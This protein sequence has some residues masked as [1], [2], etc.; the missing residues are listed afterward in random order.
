MEGWNVCTPRLESKNLP[1]L[2]YWFR[3]RHTLTILASMT[4]KILRL[5]VRCAVLVLCGCNVV[6]LYADNAQNQR[7][8]IL[9]LLA[10]DWAWPHASCLGTPGIQTPT[11]DRL[12]REGVLFRNAHVAAPSCAPS[13]AAM[14]TG[15][16]HWRLEKGV[17]LFGTLSAKF[18][19]YAT[20]LEQAGYFVAVTG[21]GYGPGFIEEIT[22]DPPKRFSP[23]GRPFKDFD[24]FQKVRPRDK[25]FCLLFG[26]HQPHRPYTVGS[27]VKG[28]IDPSKIQVPPYLP[29]N[30]VV[31]SDIADHYIAAQAF[32]REAG[33]VLAA[34][35]KSGELD[36]TLVVMSG[37]NWWP[38]P[39]CK[40]TC[41][42]TGTHQPLA[43][44][45]GRLVNPGRVVEDFVSLADIAP[46]FLEVAGLAPPKEITARSFLNVLLADKSGQVDPSRDHTLTGMERHVPS[47]RTEGARNDLPYPMRTIITKNFHFIRNFRP[48]RW[49]ACDPVDP[50]PSFDRIAG[51]T[52]LIF[53]DCDAG[54]SKAWLVTHGGEPE[55]KA[56][57]ERAFGKRPARE[58]YDLQMDPYELKNL[59]DDPAYA[60]TV[61]NFEERLMAELNS[62]GDPRASG[63]EDAFENLPAPENTRQQKR[64]DPAISK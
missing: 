30:E 62:T 55:T 7:P 59:A 22:K 27:G 37:D 2:M 1:P 34:L 31:R 46:T 57:Y 20:L 13:R 39:R 52:T 6:S 25:P 21:K 60:A 48:E 40:A 28:G 10:D 47:G 32:D 61:K 42:D 43:V 38:F 19:T 24:L 26:S 8:N 49:P 53:G 18:P 23:A 44:R 54:P 41:Y 64:N 36:N 15:Q 3:R 45:W 4:P 51:N 58:L 12:A 9:F 63:N 11:F 16:W 29:D 33:D 35:E 5:F 14:L 56:F 50:S 17:N